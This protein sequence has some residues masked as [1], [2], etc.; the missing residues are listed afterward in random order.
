MKKD[1]PW[2]LCV[3]FPRLFLNVLEH[4]WTIWDRL[5]NIYDDRSRDLWLAHNQQWVRKH[6]LKHDT[7]SQGKL[8]MVQCE[9][10]TSG[11]QMVSHQFRDGWGLSKPCW[12]VP[13]SDGQLR[14]ENNYPLQY[15][16]WLGCF[17]LVH[18]IFEQF[19]DSPNI[20]HWQSLLIGSSEKS[21][22][23]KIKFISF[24]KHLRS[25]FISSMPEA[26]WS[27]IPLTRR[28]SNTWCLPKY[29]PTPSMNSPDCLSL[30]GVQA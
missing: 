23:Q 18:P 21:A 26:Y 19:R 9:W 27:E 28:Q 14:W 17:R 30:C 2:E 16:T 13:L 6:P 29:P 5:L 15:A 20:V 12:D 1:G 8:P 11:V 3:W 24:H 10:P 7:Q 25:I 4:S 22:Q